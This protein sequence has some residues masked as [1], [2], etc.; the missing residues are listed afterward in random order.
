[1]TDVKQLVDQRVALESRLQNETS[2]L[3]DARAR[4]YDH[5]YNDLQKS[6]AALFKNVKSDGDRITIMLEIMRILENRLVYLHNFIVDA[7][8]DNRILAQ[9]VTRFIDQLS[10]DRSTVLTS[11]EA[12]YYRAV[13]AL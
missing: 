11:L 10:D 13:A 1:M 7:T 2:E 12:I 9:L 5:E 4:L 8:S 3:S 6:L